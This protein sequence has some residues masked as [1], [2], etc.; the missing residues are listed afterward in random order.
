MQKFLVCPAVGGAAITF[1]AVKYLVKNYGEGI[2]PIFEVLNR[3]PDGI[4]DSHGQVGFVE[5]DLYSPLLTEWWRLFKSR[6][7][8]ASKEFTFAENVTDSS[9]LPFLWGDYA[10]IRNMLIPFIERMEGHYVMFDKLNNDTPLRVVEVPDVTTAASPRTRR[11]V[12]SLSR[13]TRGC[14]TQGL[15]TNT[16]SS[17]S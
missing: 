14:G 1:A 5:Q 13:N 17:R 9:E 7:T 16:S 11:P 3:N 8:S 15:M 10:G 2:D 6:H 4:S 12:A